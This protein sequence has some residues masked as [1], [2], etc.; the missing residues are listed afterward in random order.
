MAIHPPCPCCNWK[1]SVMLDPWNFCNNWA[2]VVD[3]FAHGG[4]AL[5]HLEIKDEWYK[6]TLAVDEVGG[7][8]RVMMIWTRPVVC[9]PCDLLSFYLYLHCCLGLASYPTIA[10]N[11]IHGCVFQYKTNYTARFFLDPAPLDFC[12]NLV[13]ALTTITKSSPRIS[14]LELTKASYSTKPLNHA[15]PW[16][17]F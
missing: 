7:N 14:L 1:I 9:P 8:S 4:G 16:W 3:R 10:G 11:S 15:A 12:R 2:I 6:I 17:V 5:E 13:M